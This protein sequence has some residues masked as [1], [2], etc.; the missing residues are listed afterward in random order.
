MS[1]WSFSSRAT[2][3]AYGWNKPALQAESRLSLPRL[4]LIF[5]IKRSRFV[6]ILSS[7]SVRFY[8]PTLSNMKACLLLSPYRR[9]AVSRAL[10]QVPQSLIPARHVE[11]FKKGSPLRHTNFRL[12]QV[13]IVAEEIAIV[14]VR[15]FDSYFIVNVKINRFA[16]FWVAAL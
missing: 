9:R 6:L 5:A 11:T 10:S 3:R 7:S 16:K 12:R 13:R 8:L 15:R 4:L 14:N 2:S 1:S